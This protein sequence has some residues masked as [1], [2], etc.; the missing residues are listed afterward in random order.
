MHAWSIIYV[1]GPVQKGNVLHMIS[2]PLLQYWSY[3][4]KCWCDTRV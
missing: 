3:L 2:W 1:S 4:P